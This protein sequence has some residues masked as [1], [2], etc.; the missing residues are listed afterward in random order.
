[1]IFHFQKIAREL[2]IQ[3]KQVS[4]TVTLLDEGGTVPFISRYR[5]E[6]TGSLDEVAIAFIRDRI[7]QLRELD[8][9]K[10]AIIR[11]AAASLAD[12]EKAKIS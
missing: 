6:I 2:S 5:K 8:K 10:E 4:A 11:L 12:R 7:N 1:M 3:E 9:R